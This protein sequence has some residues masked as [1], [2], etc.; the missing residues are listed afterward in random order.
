VSGAGGR[1]SL[2]E[3]LQQ[4]RVEDGL[5]QHQIAERAGF[6]RSGLRLGARSGISSEKFVLF[7]RKSWAWRPNG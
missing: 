7:K 5:R 3:R 6:S 4:A 2:G 1:G